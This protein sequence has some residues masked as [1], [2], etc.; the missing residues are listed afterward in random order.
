MPVRNSNKYSP[1]E[2]GSIKIT[3][4]TGDEFFIDSDDLMVASRHCWSLHKNGYARAVIRTDSGLK[5]IYLHR[6]L[7]PTTE[8]EPHVDHADGNPANCRKQN[9]RPCTRSQ[10]MCNARRRVDNKSGFKGVNQYGAHGKFRARVRV[11]GL[12]K[13]VHGFASAE[14]AHAC[15]TMLRLQSHGAFARND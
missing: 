1:L 5:T 2:D 12:E 13:L 8:A 9:L 3:T 15:A 6:L 7:C 14:E 10:N 4:R 11:G